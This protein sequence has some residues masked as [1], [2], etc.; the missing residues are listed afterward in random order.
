LLDFDTEG[1]AEAFV[2]AHP[3]GSELPGR[4]WDG[5][6]FDGKKFIQ[7]VVNSG[8]ASIGAGDEDLYLPWHVLSEAGITSASDDAAFRKIKDYLGELRLDDLKSRFDENWEAAAVFEY[9]FQA[10]P[11]SSAVYLAA[12]CRFHY[13]ITGNDFAA[14]YLLR[15]LE[16]VVQGVENE[17]VKSMNRKKRAGEAGSK[18]S[19]KA[20]KARLEALLAE[21]EMITSRN[22]DF[23]NFDEMTIARLAVS[24]CEETNPNLWRQG[25]GQLPEYLSEIRSGS[26]GEKM[27]ARYLSIFGKTA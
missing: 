26:A 10:C 17:A 18:T 27:K 14:G 11:H 4:N 3:V 8:G 9:C 20:R 16:V 15:D 6:K 19:T 21:M 12:A 2:D 22:P 25:K 5:V 7:A 13:F 23:A 1:E 24:K